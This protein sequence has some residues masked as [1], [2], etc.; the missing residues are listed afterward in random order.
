LFVLKNI[1]NCLKRGFELFRVSL[2]GWFYDE[3]EHAQG[4]QDY[5]KKTEECTEIAQGVGA[6]CR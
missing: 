5:A 2:L 4:Q 6:C 1:F 3:Q